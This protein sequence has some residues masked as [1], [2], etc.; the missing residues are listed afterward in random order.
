M[1]CFILTSNPKGLASLCI[2]DLIERN[3]DLRCV[4]LVH[5]ENGQNNGK[6]K[7]I[8]KRIKKISKIGIL[9]ALNGIRMRKWYVTQSSDIYDVCNEYGIDLVEVEYLNSEH[10][11]SVIA[12]IDADFGISLSNGY[13][14]ERIFCTPR[15]GMINI[16]T[17]VLP[18]FPGAQSIIWPIHQMSNETGFSIHKVENKIDGGDL[19]S[20]KKV[21]IKF[22]S[23][24]A[25]T[26]MTNLKLVR[27][28]VGPELANVCNNFSSY[29]ENARVQPKNKSRTTPSLS[30]FFQMVINHNKLRIKYATKDCNKNDKSY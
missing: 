10:T 21:K 24:L 2:P 20:V 8:K 29:L 26:V 22:E 16:H 9:G 17:E 25:K 3:V 23:S 5:R 18:D 11:R 28:Q 6:I 13:I 27:S 4:V 30:Q 12:D 15:F 14:S 7:R 19:L 1:S